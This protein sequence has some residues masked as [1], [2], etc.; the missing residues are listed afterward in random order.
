MIDTLFANGRVL[1]AS[2]LAEGQAVAVAAG[3]IVWIGTEAAAPEAAQRVDLAGGLLLPGFIDV[4]VNGGGGALFND[5]PDVA[6]IATIGRAHAR[7]GTTGFLPTLISDRLHVIDAGIAAVDDAIAAGVPGVL[8]IHLEGPFINPARRG[9]HDAAKLARLSSEVL[10]R[11]TA[12]HRGRTMM[13]VAPEM[14]DPVFLRELVAGGVLVCAGHTEASIEQV[15][16]ALADGLRG[17]THLFNAMPPLLNRKPG[18]VG[19]ALEDQH[20]WCGLIV[21]G[22]HVDPVVLRLALKCRPHDRF[23]L[24]TDAMPVVGSGADSFELNS[25]TIEVRDG[26]CLSANG[27][28]AGS[29]LDMAGAVRNAIAMMGLGLGEAVAMAS[30]APAEFLGLDKELGRIAPGFR[31]SLVVAGEG[32]VVRETWVDGMRI[33]SAN[34]A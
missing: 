12:L 30:R 17:F 31:A 10:P 19:A 24:V 21:D 26:R 8:G 32:L 3:R 11:L 20:A 18:V 14:V 15:R 6:T 16:A 1:L 9:I 7:Y 4:Q 34:T 28:L 13:T 33:F 25:E 27:T 23:M 2:G 29:A 22:V 5:T